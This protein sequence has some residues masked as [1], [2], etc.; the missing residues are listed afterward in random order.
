MDELT[1]V[2][3]NTIQYNICPHI[4]KEINGIKTSIKNWRDDM[5]SMLQTWGGNMRTIRDMLMRIH[6]LYVQMMNDVIDDQHKS[7]VKGEISQLFEEINRMI[8]IFEAFN[9]G[10]WPEIFT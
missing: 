5:Q 1:K 6:E 4:Y 10:E 2:R 7:A 8:N 9:N 3:L